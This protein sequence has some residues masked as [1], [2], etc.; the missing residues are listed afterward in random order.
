MSSTAV[1]FSLLSFHRGFDRELSKELENT[2]VHFMIVPS[3]CP[4]E[5][6]SLIL[7]GAVIPKFLSPDLLKEVNKLDSIALVTPIL[8]FQMANQ[9][10]ASVVLIYGLEFDALKTLKPHWKINGSLPS[11]DREI[12]LG[13]EI[14]QHDNLKVGDNY[15]IGQALYRIS[16]VLE[17]TGSQ[18][19]AFVYLSIKNA[20]GLLKKD[21]AFTALAVKVKDTANIN[22]VIESLTKDIPGIQIVTIS[23]IL[24]SLSSVANSAKILSLS[25]AF[26]AI[27]ISAIGLMNSILMSAFERRQE[28]GM[29]RAVGAGRLDIFLIYTIESVLQTFTGSIM[30]IVISLIGSKAIETIVKKMMPYSPSGEMITFNLDIALMCLALSLSIGLIVAFYPAWIASRISPV[31]AIKS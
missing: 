8:V 14:A 20:Q 21:D 25:V 6:A 30:G 10:K 19:D 7:H 26:I 17:K 18:D 2:G 22:E 27:I 12:I 23:Q 15:P 3:G 24:N 31:E 1:L 13:Y 28:T 9:Q 5:V 11:N 16:A 29:M 4:H